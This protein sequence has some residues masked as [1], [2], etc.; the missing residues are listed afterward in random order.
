MYYEMKVKKICR[1]SSRQWENSVNKAVYFR[2]TAPP[3]PPRQVEPKYKIICGL[4][5]EKSK[6]HVHQGRLTFR[7][8]KL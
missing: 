5:I 3:R 4:Q 2:S 1:Q 7:L 8:A 6:Y